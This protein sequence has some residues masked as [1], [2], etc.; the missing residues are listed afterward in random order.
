MCVPSL[1]SWHYGGNLIYINHLILENN[2]Y[3]YKTDINTLSNITNFV[4]LFEKINTSTLS[5]TRRYWF[6]SLCI[7]CRSSSRYAFDACCLSLL[8]ESFS[9]TANKTNILK[10]TDLNK[11]SLKKNVQGNGTVWNTLQ[12]DVKV[13]L[14][15]K[16][17]K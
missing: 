3:S 13:I 5:R 8:A 11:L 2:I 16:T 6:R 10:K 9:S 4:K 14:T 1:Q 15:C 12:S 17:K 7:F